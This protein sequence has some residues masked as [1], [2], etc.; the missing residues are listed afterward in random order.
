MAKTKPP[1]LNQKPVRSSNSNLRLTPFQPAAPEWCDRVL[2]FSRDRR[3]LPSPKTLLRSRRDGAVEPVRGSGGRHIIEDNGPGVC[4]VREVSPTAISQR[5]RTL[6]SIGLA[7]GAVA[8]A[9]A[10]SSGGRIRPVAESAPSHGYAGEGGIGKSHPNV[11]YDRNRPRIVE[12]RVR[13]EA[14]AELAAAKL[15]SACSVG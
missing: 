1:L 6:D 7:D 4:E 5:G 14:P 13:K 12:V 10:E 9:E 11:A 2:K 15:P 8:E 3:G